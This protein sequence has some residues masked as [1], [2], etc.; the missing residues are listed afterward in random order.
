MGFGEIY[1][2]FKFFWMP[3]VITIK[4]RNPLT[5]SN[6]NAF[7]ARLSNAQIYFI[8]DIEYTAVLF[9]E[10]LNKLN[11]LICRVIVNND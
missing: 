5:G 10:S 6:G 7:I 8:Y 2:L 11:C 9:T 3:T 4:E 1:L